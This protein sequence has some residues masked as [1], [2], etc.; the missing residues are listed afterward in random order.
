MQLQLIIFKMS[1][2]YISFA[3]KYLSQRLINVACRR[4]VNPDGKHARRVLYSGLL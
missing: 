3:W 1:P 2:M 4:F